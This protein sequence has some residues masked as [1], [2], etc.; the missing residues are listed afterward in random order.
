MWWY[1]KWRIHCAESV[2]GIQITT[3]ILWIQWS[4]SKL[5]GCHLRV[6]L[7]TCLVA[8]YFYSLAFFRYS[9]HGFQYTLVMETVIILVPCWGEW[10]W[11]EAL[12]ASPLQP[13]GLHSWWVNHVLPNYQIKSKQAGQELREAFHR[14]GKTQS[15][16]LWMHVCVYL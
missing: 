12:I 2:G 1:T 3:V 15:R 16:I 11:E 9:C 7:L 14:I 4:L 5:P 13:P 8:G 6:L 10:Q